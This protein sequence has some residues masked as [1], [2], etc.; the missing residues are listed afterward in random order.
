MANYRFD[1]PKELNGRPDAGTLAERVYGTLREEIIRGELEP[2]TRLVRRSLSRRL[3]VSPLPVTEALLRLEM[4][5][6]V[7]SQ[8]LH[9]ARVGLITEEGLNNDQVLREAIEC[10]AARTCAEN[11]SEDELEKLF[12]EARVVD[13]LMAQGDPGSK[14]GMR[15]HLEFH[16]AIA[17]AG[18]FLRLAETLERLWFRRLMR[19]NWIKATHYKSVP[20]GWHHSLVEAIA[21]REVDLAEGRMREH[22]RYGNEDDLAALRYA[23]E[24]SDSSEIKKS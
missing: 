14:L 9:G 2:G 11:A 12:S 19:L 5:G 4:D 23:L 22:V 24:H 6:L 18:G 7:E 16:T 3:G 17:C 20:A 15:S 13:R 10:Q 8:P 1:T 21:T